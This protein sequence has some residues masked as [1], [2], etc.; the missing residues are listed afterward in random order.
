MGSFGPPTKGVGVLDGAEPGELKVDG[1]TNDEGQYLVRPGQTLHLS[2][3]FHNYGKQPVGTKIIIE[4]LCENATFAD[5]VTFQVPASTHQPPESEVVAT[6]HGTATIPADCEPLG[7]PGVAD[8]SL[9][10]EVRTAAA[11]MDRGESSTVT[12]SLAR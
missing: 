5:T 3:D 2:L 1:P 10:A 6:W 8:G 4:A 11:G 7:I 12:F 9:N